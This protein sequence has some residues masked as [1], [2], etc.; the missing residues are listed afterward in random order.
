MLGMED[1]KERTKK[2]RGWDHKTVQGQSPAA[3]RSPLLSPRLPLL[4]LSSRYGGEAAL[5]SSIMVTSGGEKTRMG[6]P[7]VP[8]PRLVCSCDP[9]GS[10]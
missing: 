2:W 3:L 1:G 5:T 6:G 10:W 8:E 9:P 7:Q 4:P